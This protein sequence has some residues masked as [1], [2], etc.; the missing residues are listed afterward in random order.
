MSRDQNDKSRKPNDTEPLERAA[1]TP[2]LATLRGLGKEREVAHPRLALDL[3]ED[4]Q[5]FSHEVSEA[6]CI[7]L[8]EPHA[9]GQCQRSASARAIQSS[10][11]SRRI[12]EKS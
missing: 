9:L 11:S 12:A 10:P 2:R 7:D 8:I 1:S 5:N 6:V 4:G 3:L